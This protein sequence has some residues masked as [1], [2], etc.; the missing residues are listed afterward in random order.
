VNCRSVSQKTVPHGKDKSAVRTKL[1]T[2]AVPKEWARKLSST[3]GMRMLIRYLL[4][5]YSVLLKANH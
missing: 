1:Y 4:R 5:R 2:N 3:W